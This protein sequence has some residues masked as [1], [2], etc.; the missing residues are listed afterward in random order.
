LIL[1]IEFKLASKGFGG[2]KRFG[3]IPPFAK[4]IYV[5]IK[6]FFE[7]LSFNGA[8]MLFNNNEGILLELFGL[9]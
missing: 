4:G 9:F 5:G 8:G 1:G 6:L 3:V 7:N 2:G